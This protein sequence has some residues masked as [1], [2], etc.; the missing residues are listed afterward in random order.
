MRA[1]V[2]HDDRRRA[3]ILAGELRSRTIE[4]PAMSL[5]G[6]AGGDKYVWPRLANR[7]RVEAAVFLLGDRQHIVE[8]DPG[9]IEAH[10]TVRRNVGGAGLR[11][12]ALDHGLGEVADPRSKLGGVEQLRRHRIDIAEIV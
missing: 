6:A 4:L 1:G 5:S 7:L 3:L 2:L 12:V 8:Q 11:L 9:L 10:R